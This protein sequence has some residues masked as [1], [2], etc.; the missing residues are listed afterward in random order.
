[1]TV[2]VGGR[3]LTDNEP[4]GGGHVLVVGHVEQVVHGAPVHGSKQRQQVRSGPAAGRGRCFTWPV[5][6]LA[7]VGT[8]H[9]DRG[10]VGTQPGLGS[11]GADLLRSLRLRTAVSVP[12]R[13]TWPELVAP[14]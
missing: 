6:V 11:V 14:G 2:L 10:S 13:G 3:G 7:Q 8:G 4:V 9:G 12:P 5:L 1:M